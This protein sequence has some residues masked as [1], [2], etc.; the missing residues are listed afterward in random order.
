VFEWN[1]SILNTNGIL[2]WS[3]GDTAIFREGEAEILHAIFRLSSSRIKSI[4]FL[5]KRVN[6][7]IN[8][9]QITL[10]HSN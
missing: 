4:F 8:I 7:D 5:N 10:F 9:R 2:I 1:F 3:R 6:I